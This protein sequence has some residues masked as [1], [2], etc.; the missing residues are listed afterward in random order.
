[1][2]LIVHERG[3]HTHTH[4]HTCAYIDTCTH[5]GTNK[6]TAHSMLMV[7]IEQLIEGGTEGTQNKTTG[8]AGLS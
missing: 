6:Q 8:A 2:F 5:S 7:G 4:A 1:M 3:V